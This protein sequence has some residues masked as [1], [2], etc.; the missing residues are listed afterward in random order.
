MKPRWF[1]PMYYIYHKNDQYKMASQ[2]PLPDGWNQL[3]VQAYV[4]QFNCI[5]HQIDYPV[6]FPCG[7]PNKL[8]LCLFSSR[9]SANVLFLLIH[10][11]VAEAIHC[12]SN[13][14]C[15]PFPGNICRTPSLLFFPSI[16]FLMK[17]L[18][19][20]PWAPSKISFEMVMLSKKHCTAKVVKD[21]Q[22]IL[23]NRAC[24][25]GNVMNCNCASLQLL[26]T[27]VVCATSLPPE[28]QPRVYCEHCC[29]Y[30]IC[31]FT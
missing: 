13:L 29:R 18:R 21:I 30:V 7:L 9:N 4:Q 24:Y 12:K 20:P 17:V 23:G 27:L 3:S 8:I 31:K 1:H 25:P 10:G 2:F 6:L 15:L 26:V 14:H 22:L 28:R 11:H 19:G 16:W 5:F